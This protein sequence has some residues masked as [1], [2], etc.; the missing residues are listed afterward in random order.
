ME[1]FEII[2]PIHL[3][4]LKVP[5]FPNGVK[6]KFA[7]LESVLPQTKGRK[8]YGIFE[9]INGEVSYKVAFEEVFADKGS[10]Y[11]CE[12]IVIEKGTYLTESI[13]DWINKIDQIGPT[14]DTLN[15]DD[16]VDTANSPSIEFY[17]SKDELVCMVK[18][19]A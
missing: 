16:R 3:F 5:A 15:Q 2:E 18:C 11:N 9:M 10:K 14:F 13:M 6:E 4:G 1:K 12:S 7:E 17:K 19:N 8:C